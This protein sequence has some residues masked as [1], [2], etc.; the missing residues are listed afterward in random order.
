MRVNNSIIVSHLVPLL[1]DIDL[2]GDILTSSVMVAGYLIYK[3]TI[4]KEVF[5]G[6]F[7]RILTLCASGHI[8]VKAVACSMVS[9]LLTTDIPQKRLDPAL[10]EYL[11]NLDYFFKN[12]TPTQKTLERQRLMLGFQSETDINST[13]L[14]NLF[15]VLPKI[16]S[17]PITEVILPGVFEFIQK[18]KIQTFDQ[19]TLKD[20]YMEIG[21]QILDKQPQYIKDM[22]ES[23]EREQEEEAKKQ[24]QMDQY[25]STAVQV[26]EITA[27]YQK[28]IQ[29][30][31]EIESESKETYLAK[32]SR[33]SI[34]IVATF[35]DKIPNLAGLIRTSEIFNIEGIVV[36]DMS[37]YQD[38]IFQQITV[39]A[40]RWLPVEE[41]TEQNLK[42]YLMSKKDEGYSLLGVEQT[43]TSVQLN[44]FQFPKKSVLLLGKEKEGI[45]TEYINLLDKCVEIPQLGVTRS[46]NVHVSG[47][48]T[49]WEYTKQNLNK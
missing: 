44:Q 16:D 39:S 46:L 18:C 42:E 20:Q 6:L 12:N 24:E 19:S 47:S 11:K 43:S 17:L 15:Y 36:G 40:E 3:E 23:A 34:I 9:N 31:A 30:W 2:R 13:D 49:I 35:I 45:P 32:K 10:F 7:T 48:I 25:I 8:V 22:V 21:K 33:Q 41:V 38:K 29:P 37:I 1:D 27:G 5:T 14:T 28:K 4:S 26:P